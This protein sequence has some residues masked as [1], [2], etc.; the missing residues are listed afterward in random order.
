MEALAVER[1][2]DG[3]GGAEVDEESEDGNDDDESERPRS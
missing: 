1:V 3:A 2:G